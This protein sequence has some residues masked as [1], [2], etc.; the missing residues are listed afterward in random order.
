MC[1]LSWGTTRTPRIQ[2]QA[3][4]TR[5]EGLK[6]YATLLRF[7]FNVA[8][9]GETGPP[10]R[11]GAEGDEGPEGEA[12]YPGDQGPPGEKGNRYKAKGI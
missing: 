2:G 4:T 3:R 11:D 9:L 8:V 12:G 6:G 1:R 10:G 5:R 7:R